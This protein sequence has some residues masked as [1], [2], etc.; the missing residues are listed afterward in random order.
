MTQSAL[1]SPGLICGAL[2]HVMWGLFPL[3]WRHLK[4]V[5]SLVVVSHRVLWSWVF[6]ALLLPLLWLLFERRPAAERSL[7][8]F[9]S[10][11]IWLIYLLAGVLI[12]INWLIF[13][14]AVGQNRV[15]EASLGYYINPLFNVLLGVLVVRERLNKLQWSAIAIAGVGVAVMAL[16]GTGFPW[17]SLLL[18]AT[19]SLYGLVKKNAPMPPLVGLLLESS[20]L[21]APAVAFLYWNS[22]QTSE[23]IMRSGTTTWLLVAGGIIT[24]MPLGLFAFAAR[25]VKLSTL[26]ILQYIGPTLQFAIGT[27]ILAEPFGIARLAGFACVWIALVIYVFGMRAESKL[28][29]L[30][31]EEVGEADDSSVTLAR[32]SYVD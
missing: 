21:L 11:K 23:P 10:P 13:I 3:Y 24:V 12:G 32:V 28:A 20:V 18:A 7:R 19:F 30:K 27:L 22:T 14:W 17:I 9:A 16:G 31:Q 25:R 8:D 2:A 4:Q 5:D 1:R 6:L 26:G 15:L 29:S